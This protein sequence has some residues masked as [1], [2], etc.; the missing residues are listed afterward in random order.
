MYEAT[1]Y[2]DGENDH[3]ASRAADSFLVTFSWFE[4]PGNF[5]FELFGNFLYFNLLVSFLLFEFL[6]DPNFLVIFFFNF[7]LSFLL[8]EFLAHFS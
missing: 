8:F 6:G 7:L 3:E 2:E 5:L 4:F 1:I